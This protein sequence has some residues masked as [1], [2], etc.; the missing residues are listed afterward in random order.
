MDGG[1]FS[2]VEKVFGKKALFLGW[3]VWLGNTSYAAMTSVGIGMYFSAIIP[4]NEV[5]ISVAVLFLFIFLNS[6]GSKRVA[7]FQ[8]PLTIILILLL[9]ITAGYLFMNPI[10]GGFTPFLP[11]GIVSLLP[12]TS[13]LFVCFTGFEAIT[14]ISAEV[15]PF[16]Y[17]NQRYTIIFLSFF[18]SMVNMVPTIWFNIFL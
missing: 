3:M 12:A 13:L 7:S 16:L 8:I 1:G 14:T 11:N 17:G 6:V 4:I 10:D 18:G 9:A 2:F 5:V 15:V